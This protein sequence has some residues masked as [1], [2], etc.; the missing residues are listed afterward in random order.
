RIPTYPRQMTSACN[1]AEYFVKI[2]FDCAL[3]GPFDNLFLTRFSASQA[4]CKGI[5]AV[6]SAST[7]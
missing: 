4:L 6:I 2:T 7:V 1:V 5:I 3:S